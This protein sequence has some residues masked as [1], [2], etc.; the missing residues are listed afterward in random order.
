MYDAVFMSS[1]GSTVYTTLGAIKKME[2]ILKKTVIWNV[3]GNASLILFFK[4]LG[5]S[6]DQIV[7]ELNRFELVIN[8]FNYSSLLIENDSTKL[9]YIQNWLVKSIEISDYIQPSSTLADIYAKTGFF[10]CFIIWDSVTKEIVNVNPKQYPGLPFI[11]CIMATLCGIGTFKHYKLKSMVSKNLFAIDP[12]PLDFVFSL[13][14][15]PLNYLYIVNKSQLTNTE[16]S[17][18]GPLVE[19]ENSLIEEQF[20]R[21]SNCKLKK[22]NTLVLYSKLLRVHAIDELHTLYELGARM[23]ETFLEGRSTFDRYRSELRQI[24][25]QD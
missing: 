15:K 17:R 14:D 25:E 12:A 1:Y 11:D 7:D 19:S 20:D 4:C 8:M 16:V 10:P 23:C 21:F 9:K 13:E 3:M 22:E 24:E 6:C 18:L 5:Y 2:R